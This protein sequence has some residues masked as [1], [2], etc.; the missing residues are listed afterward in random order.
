MN[1]KDLEEFCS[2]DRAPLI[3]PFSQ[4]EFTFAS[5][6]RICIAVPRLKGVP[7]RQDAPNNVMKNIFDANPNNGNFAL[8]S[9]I[10]IPEL[11][12]YQPCKTCEGSGECLCKCC[13]VIHDCGNC[14]GGG[15]V[16]ENTIR[17]TIGRHCVSHILLNKIK[18]LPNICIAE[19]SFS[20][21]GALTFKFDGGEGRLSPMKKPADEEA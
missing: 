12:G 14:D 15:K 21:M 1:A 10:K 17:V 8:L 3:S 11:K 7:E 6:G 16:P 9:A 18:H 20:D 13:E 5:E 19:S 2:Q 4:G